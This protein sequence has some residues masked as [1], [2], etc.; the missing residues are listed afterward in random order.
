M[1]K[2]VA[3]D[4]FI[5]GQSFRAYVEY[6]AGTPTLVRSHNVASISDLGVGR[7]Q[8]FIDQDFDDADYGIGGLAEAS[9][10]ASFLGVVGEAGG[11]AAGSIIVQIKNSSD[12]ATDPNSVTLWGQRD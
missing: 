9:S 11:R 7:L 12:T 2:A 3:K 8:V 5:P 10:G 1:L 6:S 4:P